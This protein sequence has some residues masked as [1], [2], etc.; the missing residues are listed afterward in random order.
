[1]AGVDGEGVAVGGEELD[2][3]GDFAFGQRKLDKAPVGKRP[4]MEGEVSGCVGAS[5]LDSSLG[6]FASLRMTG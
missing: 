3:V 5:G 2:L 4:L 6:G 1:M